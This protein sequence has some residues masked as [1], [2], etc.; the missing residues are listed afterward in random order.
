MMDGCISCWMYIYFMMDVYSYY[1]GWRYHVWWMVS[2]ILLY[3]YHGSKDDDV[4]LFLHMYIR[5][6]FHTPVTYTVDD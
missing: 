1:D 2:F 5:L 3:L 6:A 4:F